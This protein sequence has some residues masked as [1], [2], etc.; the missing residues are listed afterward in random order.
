MHK[1]KAF[2]YGVIAASGAT[3]FQQLIL[4]V[5]NIEIVATDHLTPLLIFGALS[6]EIFK[7]IVIYKI[8]IETESEKN[9]L[10]N[11]WL[12]G[13]GFSIIELIFKIWGKLPDIRIFYPDYLGIIVIHMLTAVIIGYFLTLK[14]SKILSSLAGITLAFLIHLVY[15]TFKI[16]GF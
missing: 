13:F 3:V 2:F 9:L 4:I 12:V 6:E 15:N 8:Y 14:K 10:I 7:F 5:L 1:I 11:S 16:Y